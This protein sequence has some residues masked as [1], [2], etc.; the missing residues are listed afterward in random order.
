MR[1]GD[2]FTAA[3]AKAGYTQ[4]AFALKAHHHPRNLNQIA[5]GERLPPLKHIAAWTKLLGEHIDPALF[6][7]LAELEHCPPNI[8]ARY[9]D[10]QER[11]KGKG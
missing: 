10:M 1:F 4:R 3:M 2:Y 6:L 11:L 7:E 9:L 5:Q 8:R